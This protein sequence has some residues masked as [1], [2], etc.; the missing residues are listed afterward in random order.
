M[1]Q[2]SAVWGGGYKNLLFIP[3]HCLHIDK[4]LTFKLTLHHLLELCTSIFHS[5]S[6]TSRQNTF[7]RLKEK[8]SVLIKNMLQNIVMNVNNMLIENLFSIIMKSD[9]SS[10]WILF[11][12]NY[13]R[14]I[15]GGNKIGNSLYHLW[16]CECF[17]QTCFLVLRLLYDHSLDRRPVSSRQSPSPWSSHACCTI[18]SPNWKGS[19]EVQ[20]AA[21]H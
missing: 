18:Q 13:L 8:P 17:T 7:R 3:L 4:Y 9:S 1:P 2:F 19:M 14:F 11:H 12:Q 6:R 15:C 10:A 21:A 16:N 20:P 5:L